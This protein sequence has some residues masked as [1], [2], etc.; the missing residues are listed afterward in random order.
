VGSQCRSEQR[1]NGAPNRNAAGSTRLASGDTI[2]TRRSEVGV[3]AR[4]VAK[5]AIA[6]GGNAFR[7]ARAAGGHAFKNARHALGAARA[8]VGNAAGAV[9][10]ARRAT[11]VGRTVHVAG[12]E[13]RRQKRGPS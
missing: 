10:D 5:S 4:T 1:Q 11:P 8:T 3:D 7:S 12:I 6:E 9:A 2:K 13:A